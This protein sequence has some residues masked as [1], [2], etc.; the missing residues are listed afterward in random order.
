MKTTTL[1]IVGLVCGLSLGFS[2]FAQVRFEF[3]DTVKFM[4]KDV[5]FGTLHEY[6]LIENNTSDTLNMRWIKQPFGRY[7]AVW[8][9]YFSDPDSAYGIINQIDSGSFLLKPK[10]DSIS[11]KLIFGVEHNGFPGT[12]RM[13]FT[14]FEIGDKQGSTNISFDIRVKSLSNDEHKTSNFEVYPTQSSTGEFTI[15]TLGVNMDPEYYIYD[16]SGKSVSYI[17]KKNEN[18]TKIHLHTSTPGLYFLQIGKTIP[19]IKKLIITQ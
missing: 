5:S 7:P 6:I 3:A 8:D 13:G 11:H 15:K 12:A 19:E 17:L 4:E 1:K 14:L 2:G 18:F 16:A 10:R 9:T